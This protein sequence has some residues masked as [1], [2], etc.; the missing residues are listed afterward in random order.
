MVAAWLLAACLAGCGGDDDGD[1]DARW[2]IV[3]ED[4]PGGLL[5]LWGTSSSD[6]W[7]VGGNP[8]DGSGA[9]VLRFDGQSWRRVD[10][11]T[12][13]DL[14]WVHGFAGGPVF[15]AGS[16]GTIL[17]YEEG[18]VQPLQTPGTGIVFGI[19]GTSPDDLW[20]VGGDPGG[21]AGAFVWRYDGSEWRV[22]D[23]APAVGL[24]HYFKVWG[25]SA[26]DVRI[27]GMDGV[28]LEYDG[29]AFT[30][31]DSPTTNRL[32]T[33]HAGPDG[34]YAAVG[35][36]SSAVIVESDGSEW[37]D[38]SPADAKQLFGVRLSGDGGYAVGVGASV[39]KRKKGAWSE[40]ET[41]LETFGDLH[42]VWID[43][44]GGVWA[45]GGDIVAPPLVR[46]M[47]LHKGAKKIPGGYE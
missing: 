21:A 12:T 8:G 30:V 38:S 1:G 36:R 29:N 11:G 37:K 9:F 45:A 43:P 10:V 3:H 22:E 34:T 18:N 23:G 19:W 31:A 5:S 20:A 40:E 44:D 39:L 6:V 35:G 4:L 28:I 32:L 24:T 17:R 42:S 14:W 27:V 7:T 26:T 46:G 13:A 47:L 33:V 15:M 25:R 2:R 16:N 41:G